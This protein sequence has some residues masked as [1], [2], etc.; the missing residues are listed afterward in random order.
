MTYYLGEAILF[1]AL[2]LTTLQAL[3]MRRELRQVR[4]YQADYHL[5][6][7][8]TEAALGAIQQTIR[9]LQ[10]NGREVI[11]ELGQRIDAGKRLVEDI[12]ASHPTADTAEH[13]PSR[14]RKAA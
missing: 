5:A 8:K 1:A 7:G 13:I 2:V 14:R 4:A 12:K 9:E 3:R 11:E 6:L 10:T